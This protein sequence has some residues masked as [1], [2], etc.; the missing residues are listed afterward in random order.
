[1]S[2]QIKEI[3]IDWENY[4]ESWWTA[5][6]AALNDGSAPKFLRPILEN[7]SLVCELNVTPKEARQAHDWATSLPGWY[8]GPEHAPHPLLID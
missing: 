7:S 3:K 8:E 4:T 2:R 6:H 5:A 1:M